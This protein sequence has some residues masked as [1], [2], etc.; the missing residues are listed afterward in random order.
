[1]A[2][3]IKYI[4]LIAFLAIVISLATALFHLVK[5]KE[6]KD[7]HKTAKALTIRIGLSL[8]LFILLFLAFVTGL[9]Q[10]HGIGV[11]MHSNP[12]PSSLTPQQ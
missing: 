8:A 7:S 11:R 9:I 5:H 2:M 10:P 6:D 1:V 12:A 4:T 3:L